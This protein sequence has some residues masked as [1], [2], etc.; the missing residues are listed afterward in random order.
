MSYDLISQEVTKALNEMIMNDPALREI[1][2]SQPNYRYYINKETKDKY[3]YTTEKMNR[4][5]KPRYVSGIYRY[6]KSRR[7]WKPLAQA[8]HA[9]RK[10]ADARALRLFEANR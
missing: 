7:M 4:N 9:K 3:F 2:P 6:L 5:G 8:G 10:D 1:F